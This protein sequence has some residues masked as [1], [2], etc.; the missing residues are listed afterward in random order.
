MGKKDLAQ[1]FKWN[2]VQAN[3]VSPGV[4]ADFEPGRLNITHTSQPTFSEGFGVGSSSIRTPQFED[5]NAP[6]CLNESIKVN[7][8][9]GFKSLSS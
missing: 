3:E 7:I 9:F 1:K 4:L 2:R 8:S 5:L 6:K